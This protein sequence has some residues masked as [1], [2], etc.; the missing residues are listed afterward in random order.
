[1]LAKGMQI[2]CI[3][4]KQWI[5]ILGILEKRWIPGRARA[6]SIHEIL[7]AILLRR[8]ESQGGRHNRTPAENKQNTD[9][10]N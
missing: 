3:L 1:M 4:E 9:K 8:L 7:F 2:L 5:Q 6:Y 10:P